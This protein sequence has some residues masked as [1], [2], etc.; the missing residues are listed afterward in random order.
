[1]RSDPPVIGLATVERAAAAGFRGIAV[2]AGG[3]LILESAAIGRAAD[4]AGMF[5]VGVDMPE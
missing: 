3:T 4:A 5:I 1:M 2:E